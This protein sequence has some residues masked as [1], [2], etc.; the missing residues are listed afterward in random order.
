MIAFADT[1]PKAVFWMVV[2]VALIA[3]ITL[4]SIFSSKY[5]KFWDRKRQED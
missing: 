2:I 3:G 1:W 4:S 5:D